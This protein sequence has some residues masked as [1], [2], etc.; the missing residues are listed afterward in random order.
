METSIIKGKIS[1]LQKKKEQKLWLL[2]DFQYNA[3]VPENNDFL[4]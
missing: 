1:Q 3:K 2:S 4:A